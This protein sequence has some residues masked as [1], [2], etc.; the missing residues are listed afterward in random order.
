MGVR[1]TIRRREVQRQNR[2]LR[3]VKLKRASGRFRG[4]Q[5]GDVA[6]AGGIAIF[7]NDKEVAVAGKVG[8]T[9]RCGTAGVAGKLLAIQCMRIRDAARMCIIAMHGEFDDSRFV[10]QLDA[11]TAH[12]AAERARPGGNGFWCQ[13][14]VVGAFDTTSEASQS[15]YCSVG[16]WSGHWLHKVGD[17]LCSRASDPTPRLEVTVLGDGGDL[18]VGGTFEVRLRG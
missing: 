4:W 5:G 14:Y 12:A 13:L 7:V 1:K 3:E 11:V 9:L 16:R 6:P 2:T 17:G 15:Q 18:F 8:V 10:R